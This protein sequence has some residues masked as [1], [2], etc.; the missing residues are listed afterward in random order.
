[1]RVFHKI[2][3]STLAVFAVT[4]AALA[5]PNS[6]PDPVANCLSA[7]MLQ[8]NLDHAFCYNFPVE[9]TQ[10]RGQCEAD[11][12]IKY[13]QAVAACSSKS[14]SVRTSVSAGLK[15]NTDPAFLRRLRY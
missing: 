4:S 2:A 3:L 5:A 14:A 1:M 11:A 8:F 13:A 12:N 9:A 7:A 15:Q 6:T 10:L